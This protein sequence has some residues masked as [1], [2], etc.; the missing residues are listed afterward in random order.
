[1][2]S[3][4]CDAYELDVEEEDEDKVKRVG[5]AIDMANAPWKP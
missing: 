4:G 5:Q 1:V 3:I 2:R